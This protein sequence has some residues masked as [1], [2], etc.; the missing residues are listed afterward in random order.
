MY[1]LFRVILVCIMN[2]MRLCHFLFISNN[3][4]MS[5]TFLLATDFNK[6]FKHF[7]F[8]F[9]FFSNRWPKSCVYEPVILEFY[10]GSKALELSWRR[11]L[12]K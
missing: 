10:Y 11:R 3:I 9:F 2:C 1:F 7:S 4:R 5:R 12:S 6:T 8:S